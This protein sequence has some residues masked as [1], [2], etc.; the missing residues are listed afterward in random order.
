M[1][2]AGGVIDNL[3]TTLVLLEPVTVGKHPGSYAGLE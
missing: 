3:T 2:K 1:G